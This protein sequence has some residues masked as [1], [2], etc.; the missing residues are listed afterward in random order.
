[1]AE[2]QHLGSNKYIQVRLVVTE[3]RDTHGIS[4]LTGVLQARRT[5]AWNGNTEHNGDATCAIININGTIKEVASLRVDGGQ[6]NVWQD[7]ASLTV[8]VAHTSAV[9]VDFSESV[10]GTSDFDGNA[11]GIINC[12]SF[13]SGNSG[14]SEPTPTYTAP[15]ISSIAGSASSPDTIAVFGQVSAFGDGS[16]ANSLVLGV[17]AGTA[18]SVSGGRRQVSVS[19]NTVEQSATID[20]STDAFDGG[21]VIQANS[22]Y[23]TYAYASNGEKSSYALTSVIWTPPPAITKLEATAGR[24]A[25]N[26]S[27]EYSGLAAEVAQDLYYRTMVDG[28]SFTEWAKCGTIPASDKSGTFNIDVTDTRKAIIIEARLYYPESG[29]YGEIKTIT[30]PT[31]GGFY[32]NVNGK[33][34]FIQRSYCRDEN[35]KARILSK[36]YGRDEEGK[37]RRIF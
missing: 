14:T 19:A 30:L 13:G 12:A 23:K 35:G 20:N 29:K 33:A 2:C 10:D 22:K 37:A 27:C 31:S 15:S 21:I 24:D 17:V 5:N 25:I 8:D 7:Q 6:Q 4:K 16:G 26:I 1:M 3:N 36:L 11:T 32:A 9:T 28:K 18:T 34:K